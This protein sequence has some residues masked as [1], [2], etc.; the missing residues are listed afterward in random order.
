MFCPKCGTEHPDDSQ[1]CRKCGQSLAGIVST[2]TGTVV[3]KA[4]AR[5]VLVA[6]VGGVIV[7]ILVPVWVINNFQQKKTTANVPVQS[8]Q[9][10]AAPVVDTANPT[11]ASPVLN[12][13][14]LS[15]E[16]IYKTENAGMILIETYDDEGRKRGLGSGFVVAS[17]G[18][19]IT[20]YHVIRGA[21]RATVKFSDGT[22]GSVGGVEA[23][24]QARD[25]S[26]ITDLHFVGIANL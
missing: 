6:L 15:P 19:A 21:S 23:Y 12:P 14:V 25:L 9:S 2:S 24:D 1:F 3:A 13:R 20:N 7:L 8:V 5:A 11:P 26:V 10:N 18:T 4:N 16:E 17:D 22:V